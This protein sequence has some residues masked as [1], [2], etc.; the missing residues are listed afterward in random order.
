LEVK[1][2]LFFVI[3]IALESIDCAQCT[4]DCTHLV[5]GTSTMTGD[6]STATDTTICISG[7]CS[8]EPMTFDSSSD[9]V[10]TY[11]GAV[12]GSVK[13]TPAGAITLQITANANGFKDGDVYGLLVNAGAAGTLVA[14]TSAAITY[15][16]VETCGH[17]CEQATFTF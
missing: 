6:V 8:T 2:A 14:R 1:I 4:A 11:S 7:A 10:A 15:T 9:A 5:T 17:T 12:T 16:R 3:V 13:I